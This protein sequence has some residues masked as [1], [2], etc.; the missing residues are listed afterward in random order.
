MCSSILMIL[1]WTSWSLADSIPL[2]NWRTKW[3]NPV[4][5]AS[6]TRRIRRS[7]LTDLSGGARSALTGGRFISLLDRAADQFEVGG[8]QSLIVHR[9][10][11]VALLDDLQPAHHVVGQILRR[12]HDLVLLR[13]HKL[14]PSKK[15]PAAHEVRGPIEPDGISDLGGALGNPSSP[16]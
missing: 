8:R 1:T 11:Q 10:G 15:K 12:H 3:T 5:C 13:S 16:L 6:S 4:K 2:S 9:Q 14:S 7:R